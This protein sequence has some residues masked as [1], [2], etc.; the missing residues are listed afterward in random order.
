MR[1]GPPEASKRTGCV[2]RGVS[3]EMPYL[4]R[5]VPL[6]GTFSNPRAKLEYG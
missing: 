5:M 1:T 6:V 2:M 3:L 4:M